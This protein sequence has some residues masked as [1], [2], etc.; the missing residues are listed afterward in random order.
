M[1]EQIKSLQNEI[2]ALKAQVRSLQGLEILN[3]LEWYSDKP[4]HGQRSR[5]EIWADILS[6]FKPELIVETG[7]HVGNTCA[8]L[9]TFNLPVITI[10]ANTKLFAFAHMRL[11][12][13][14]NVRLLN[15]DSASVLS[16]KLVAA[17]SQRIFF[18]LDAHWLNSL[19]LRQEL[20]SIF[21]FYPNTAIMIDD[22][23]VPDD[24][25]YG[26][27]DYGSVIGRLTLDYIADIIPEESLLFYPQMRSSDDTGTT[28]GSLIIARGENSIALSDASS[29]RHKT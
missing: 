10:E 4:F 27:D 3:N 19:P 1:N 29:L 12:N 20:T 16:E 28:R 18:Y 14:S 23:Q 5:T 21:S 22:F 13:K 6:I 26:W 9:S 24:E 7:T 15:G 8:F 25:G 11:G 2:E 17:S